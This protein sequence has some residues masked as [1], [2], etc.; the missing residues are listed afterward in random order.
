[1]WLFPCDPSVCSTLLCEEYP[2]PAHCWT[3][4][5]FLYVALTFSFA[6]LH[7]RNEVEDFTTY[8][9][10]CRRRKLDGGFDARKLKNKQ[11]KAP[12]RGLLFAEC[13]FRTRRGIG[14]W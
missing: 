13:S 3:G 9:R 1:M 2:R 5:D 7:S 12:T 4:A 14:Q 6:L 10:H 11:A 8:K